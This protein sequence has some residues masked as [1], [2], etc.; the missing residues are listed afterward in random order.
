[1]M[2][3]NS[4]SNLSSNKEVKETF[5]HTGIIQGENLKVKLNVPLVQPYMT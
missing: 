1:M 3:P 5:S 4:I 2:D